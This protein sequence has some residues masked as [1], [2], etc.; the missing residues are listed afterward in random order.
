MRVFKRKA[1]RAKRVLKRRAKKVSKRR[2]SSKKIKRKRKAKRVTKKS[3]TGS[4]WRVWSGTAKYT[5]GGLTKKDLCKSKTGKV[6]SKKRSA[7]GKKGWVKATQ[8]ARK[9][10]GLTGFVACKRGTEYYKL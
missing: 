10:L 1:R 6:V 2:K 5:K 7:I 4:M 3:L 8:A 9:Q